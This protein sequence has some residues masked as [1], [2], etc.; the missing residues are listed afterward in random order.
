MNLVSE[1][2][3]NIILNG[4]PQKSFFKC[5]YKKYTNYGLQKFR[6]DFEGTPQLSLTAESTFTFK[7]KRYADLLMDCYISINLPNIW[8]PILP[9]QTYENNDGTTVYSDWSPYEFAWIKNL[10]AQIIS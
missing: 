7:I 2:Q 9:P 10:G 8:S 6:L 4:N 3:Q 5:T 1:G